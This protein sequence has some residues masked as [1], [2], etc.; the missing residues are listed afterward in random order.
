MR[1]RAAGGDY[2]TMAKIPIDIGEDTVNE[3]ENPEL[4]EDVGAIRQA[5][6][7][8]LDAVEEVEEEA[9]PKKSIKDILKTKKISD[10]RS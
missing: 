9:A 6:L 5:A 7:A 10:L 8:A 1:R 3:N 2:A 4:V